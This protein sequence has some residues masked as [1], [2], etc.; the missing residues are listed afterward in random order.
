MVA[1]GKAVGDIESVSAEDRT[2]HWPSGLEGFFFG[3]VELD[4]CPAKGT[5]R[6]CGRFYIVVI[7]V[8][9]R[10]G[11]I[12]FLPLFGLPDRNPTLS[13]ELDPI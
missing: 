4:L 13:A 10:G 7:L 11:T 8:P 12:Q 2:A 5:G 1:D 9:A 6:K 3:S